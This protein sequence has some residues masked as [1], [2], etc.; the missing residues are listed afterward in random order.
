MCVVIEEVKKK[1]KMKIETAVFSLYRIWFP[2][3]ALP[4]HRVLISTELLVYI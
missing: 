3:S 1:V 2:F 4:Y